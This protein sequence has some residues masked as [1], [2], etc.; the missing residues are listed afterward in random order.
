M[1]GIHQ[2]A[3]DSGDRD[4][5]DHEISSAFDS[6]LDQL[7]NDLSQASL[8]SITS[9]EVYVP[10]SSNQFDLQHQ[11]QSTSSSTSLSRKSIQ[12]PLKP[13]MA[14]LDQ[15]MTV[16]DIEAC[17]DN[18]LHQLNVLN[19][20]EEQWIGISNNFETVLQHLHKCSGE[21]SNTFV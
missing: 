18:D 15:L 9:S 6:N 19:N 21:V 7:A 2:A 13:L 12:P 5:P 17:L 8:I 1:A 11:Q 20:I 14:P 3:I 16:S 4:S 10:S